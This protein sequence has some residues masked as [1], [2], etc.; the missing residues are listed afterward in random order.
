MLIH[1][2]LPKSKNKHNQSSPHWHQIYTPVSRQFLPTTDSSF[3]SPSPGSCSS[4]IAH[5]HS[6]PTIIASAK[7]Q[8][9]NYETST[10]SARSFVSYWLLTSTVLY[11]L[12]NKPNYYNNYWSD[13]L[14]EPQYCAATLHLHAVPTQSGTIKLTLQWNFNKT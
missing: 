2:Q 6:H 14:S 5:W 10:K 4:S 9:S 7:M 3:I 13:Y 1:L 12:V 8:S 11:L